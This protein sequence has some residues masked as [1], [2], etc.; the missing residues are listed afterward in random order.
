MAITSHRSGQLSPP[1]SKRPKQRY[2]WPSATVREG[3]RLGEIRSSHRADLG[4]K[5]V[6]FESFPAFLIGRFLS[7]RRLRD[8]VISQVDGRRMKKVNVFGM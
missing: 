2:L 7:R 4:R 3:T 1:T 5:V 8:S 6:V